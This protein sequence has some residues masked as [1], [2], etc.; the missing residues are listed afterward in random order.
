LKI[1]SD[2]MNNRAATGIAT[3]ILIASFIIIT[4]TAASVLFDDNINVSTE[5]YE[6]IIKETVD[7]ISTYI[8]IKEALGKYY[9]IDE[10]QYI[11]KIAILIKPLI[12]NNIDISNLMIKINNGNQV[13]FISYSEKSELIKS[14]SL[15]EHP[16]WDAIQQDNFGFI[17][18]TDKD[19]SLIDYNTLNSNTD[20]AY[21]I[22]KLP[23]DFFM[24]SGDT[25]IINLI[26]STGIIKTITVQAP[27]PMTKVV[28]LIY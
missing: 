5:D 2:D 8:Q 28:S 7:E 11:Q 3:V 20:L 24:I 15:F 23:E 22:I 9:Q 25:L 6:N 12:S 13:K 17:V 18:T 26:P 21:I 1:K 19:R 27:M 4:A 16:I 14:S 10:N